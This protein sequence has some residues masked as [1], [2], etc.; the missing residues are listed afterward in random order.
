MS[1]SEIAQFDLKAHA[2]P[3]T[4]AAFYEFDEPLTVSLSSG[5]NDLD[6]DP[7]PTA[8]E[9]PAHSLAA[10]L[11]ERNPSIA[12]EL[13]A[14]AV[15][16][17][18]YQI[19]RPIGAG[20]SAMLFSA[21]DLQGGYVTSES[22]PR[23]ALKILHPELRH[24][25]ARIR[26]LMREF[27]YMRRLTHPS[28]ARVFDLQSDA[29]VWFMVMEL[30]QGRSL[31]RYLA[32][33]GSQGLP[34]RQAVRL[35][36]QCTEALVCAHERGVCH[37]D[38]KPGNVLIDPM[39]SAHLVDFGAVC[40]ADAEPQETL[41]ATPAYASPQLLNQRIATPRDDLFSLGC[42]AYELF[43]G[44]HPYGLLS[45]LE[46]RRKAMH[47]VYDPRIPVELF[48][49]IEQLLAWERESRPNDALEF[50]SSLGSVTFTEPSSLVNDECP[51]ETSSQP[52][53]TALET[54]TTLELAPD[55]GSQFAAALHAKRVRWIALRQEFEYRLA[56]SFE[57]A[58]SW[59]R[60][61]L[62]RARDSAARRHLLDQ[63]TSLRR[64]GLAFLSESL[65]FMKT[66]T[67]RILHRSVFV[68]KALTH[69]TASKRDTVP[70]AAVAGAA[71]MAFLV[72]H[73]SNAA[74]A[75]FRPALEPSLQQS[76]A[77]LAYIPIALIEPT[78]VVT[79][80]RHLLPPPA[81]P[82]PAVRPANGRV[83]LTVSRVRVPA[84]QQM[85]VINLRRD[86]ST[87]GAAP[88]SWT[89]S[90]G[91][92]KPGID[93]EVPKTRVARFNDGQ[94]V[95]TLFIPLKAPKSGTRPERRFTIKLNK[96][97]QGP[98]FGPITQAEVVISGTG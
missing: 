96:T 3:G 89:I 50:L 78:I 18:R 9:P 62:A 52:E 29:G 30:L 22:E 76:L 34:V 65:M 82:T 74:R 81:P 79:E 13:G 48:E 51:G 23:V 66:A 5:A 44:R 80:P 4:A 88:V 10:E 97:P 54:P 75:P 36:T 68:S 1:N 72:L 91:T 17:A 64:Q 19:E 95:R 92:A 58:M 94:G 59:S 37:G 47:P 84:G 49:S 45:S 90:P 12:R 39:G 87:A 35:L 8:E 42:I 53:A 98:E 69:M 31:T 14:G 63:V 60:H 32:E 46:A 33:H 56:L 41:F 67:V 27:G 21:T 26:R 70:L 38:L 55:A 61:A 85:A 43:T 16:A 15:L 40:P 83:W 71:A 7:S 73:W 20:G 93:Y 77:G 25:R 28:I 86:K 2:Y 24:Q 57:S 6:I 11:A